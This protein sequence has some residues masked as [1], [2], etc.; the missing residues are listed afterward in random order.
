MANYFV[1]RG[2]KIFGPVTGEQVIGLARSQKIQPTDQIATDK[3]GPW[4]PTTALPPLKAVFQQA[5]AGPLGPVNADPLGIGPEQPEAEDSG[6]GI[7]LGMSRFDLE[8]INGK[9]SKSANSDSEDPDEEEK[10]FSLAGILNLVELF[11]S[12]MGDD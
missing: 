1:R 10:G 7:P 2:E 8:R 4:Q 6:D 9:R 12:I 11:T 3:N 5:S